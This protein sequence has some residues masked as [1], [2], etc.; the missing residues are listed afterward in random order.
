MPPKG[1]GRRGRYRAFMWAYEIARACDGRLFNCPYDIYINK[2]VNNDCE[3]EEN[4]CC[5]SI[6]G[7]KYIPSARRNGAVIVICEQECDLDM[8][9]ISVPSVRKALIDIAA[10][11]RQRNFGKVIC[12]TGS[13]GKT[14]VKDLI[15]S[16]LSDGRRVLKTKG[17]KNNL[18]GLPLTVLSAEN[19]DI[20]VLEAGIS[21]KGEM[22]VISSI[23]RPD[24][25]V[26]TNIGSMHSGG[27]GGREEIAYEKLKILESASPDCITVI[28][29]D[30][31][32]LTYSGNR[33]ITVGI[34]STNA[35]FNVENI[36][37]SE[38]GSLFDIRKRDSDLIKDMFLP[39]IGEHFCYDGAVA[40]A[41]AELCG[42]SEGEIRRG[43]SEYKSSMGRQNM[44]YKDG[45]LFIND[46]Y[47]CGPESALAS[48]KAFNNTCM[49][50]GIK[51]RIAVLGDM[52]ELGVISES[53]HISLGKAVA[54]SGVDTL[55]ALGE[56]SQCIAHGAMIGGMDKDEIYA[57]TNCERDL[58]ARKVMEQAVCGAALLF[59]GSRR[60]KME[61]LIPFDF[62][63]EMKENG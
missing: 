27:L 2:I 24:I 63:E 18:L 50:K 45:V 28:P 37:F 23:A 29:T 42:A 59:K 62:K 21:E 4:C 46:A 6:G 31:P 36:R 56:Y 60:M 61:E 14:T 22:S 16:A 38:N 35:S 41:V 5:A 10:F 34:G 13:A 25:A 19:A 9:Y 52:L 39:L 20:A 30:E 58:A 32:L 49:I 53:M 8:P 57:F 7:E 55:I 11:Y 44:I 40:Y 15:Y 51:H 12:V 17:N 47:N 48:L 33:R 1:R 54:S 43:F 26:I 3:C